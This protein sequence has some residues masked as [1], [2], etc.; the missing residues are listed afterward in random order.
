MKKIKPY[1]ENFIRENYTIMT[2][3]ELAKALGE[4]VTA[5]DIQYWLRKNNLWKEKYMFTDESIK[6]MID[7]YKTMTY[8][9]IAKH[10][11]LTER[12]VKGKL[13][14]M[15]YTKLREFNK[16][17]FHEIDSELKAYLLGFIFA[18]GWVTHNT[19][20][21]NY[22]FGMELQS[23]DRCIL[24]ALNNELGGVHIISHS[25]PTQRVIC[26]RLTNIGHMDRL[27]VY[28]REFVE[29][30]ISHGIVP[31]KTHDCRIPSFPKEFFFDFLRGYIDGDGCYSCK[32]NHIYMSLTCSSE[33]VLKWVQDVLKTY[34]ITTSVYK[35]KEY[36]YKLYCTSYES[37]KSLINC[38]YHKDCTLY[39]TRKYD[40]IKPLLMP[41]HSEM[42]G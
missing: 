40:K 4:N 15:G 33:D 5:S 20:Q 28:S 38:M 22:E 30:L 16:G 18:D 42:F 11:G 29:D 24:E 23:R 9:E 3:K 39:L 35:E 34:N 12:Q 37:M 25:N 26:G 1:M 2:Q 19:K 36:K 7:N 41:S 10:I 13:N 32:K 14:N 8:K 21:R 31:N 17:Y 6:F 27:R